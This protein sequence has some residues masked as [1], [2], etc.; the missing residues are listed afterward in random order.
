LNLSSLLGGSNYTPLSGSETYLNVSLTNV[1]GSGT[2]AKADITV[3]N[4]AVT[5]V[6]IRSGGSGYASGNVLSASASNIGGTGSGFQITANRADTRLYVDLVGSKTK[7]NATSA[8]NDYFEDD[9]APVVSITNLATFS[10]FSFS[11]N[12]DI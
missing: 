6:T 4:G 1:S 8:V 10:T 7:F 2:G 9:N 5:D 11:G 12:T 3:T